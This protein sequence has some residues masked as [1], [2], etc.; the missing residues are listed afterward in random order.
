[1]AYLGVFDGGGPLPIPAPCRDL[2]T[3][4]PVGDKLFFQDSARRHWKSQHINHLAPMLAKPSEIFGRIGEK[5][6]AF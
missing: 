3:S 1:M 2:R 6:V 4:R 5:T